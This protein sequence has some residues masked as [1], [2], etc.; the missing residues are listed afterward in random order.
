[1]LQRLA[2]Q[3]NRNGLLGRNSGFGGH[4]AQQRDGIAVL[5]CINSLLQRR[6]LLAVDNFSDISRLPAAFYL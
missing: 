3:V 5:R 4:V 2:V 6:I 1:M